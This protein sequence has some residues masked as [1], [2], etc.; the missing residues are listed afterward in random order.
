MNK[1]SAVIITFNEEQYLGRCLKSLQK[2]AD[3]IV[4]VDSFSTDN[5]QR[6]AKSYG[7]KII[8][9]KFLGYVEQKNF[10]I[11]QAE[12]D[13][14]ISLDGD[15]ALSDELIN[16]IKKVKTAFDYK[17]YSFNRLNNYCGK[18]IRHSGWYPDKKIRLFKKGK[19]VWKGTNPHDHLEPI[20]SATVKHLK[21]DLLHWPYDT[22]REHYLKI[23]DFSSIS[24][25]AM[26]DKGR[27]A[28]L[29]DLLLRPP[30]KFLRNYLLKGGYKDGVDGLAICFSS[31]VATFLRYFKLYKLQN[32]QDEDRI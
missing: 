1:L 28:G 30:W 19:A 8:E 29:S 18:W 26:W 24:A 7:A 27:K 6:I 10:A 23:N 14:V 2:I 9:Q 15:E 5:T 22:Y 16:S 25:K 13:F 17:V 12:N 20:N 11:N 4:V 3:E 32:Q 31:G 21:G